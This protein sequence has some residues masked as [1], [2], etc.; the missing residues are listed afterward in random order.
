MKRKEM[1]YLDL[2]SLNQ[3]TKIHR[4]RR[5]VHFSGTR[6]LC[7]YNSGA[8]SRG[9]FK[10]RTTTASDECNKETENNQNQIEKSS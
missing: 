4:F 5:I 2:Q 10:G 8:G 9:L 1:L 6:A 3:R 7:E